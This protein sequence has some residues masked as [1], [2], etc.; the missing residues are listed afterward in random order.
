V[1]IAEL[2]PAVT[3][4]PLSADVEPGWHLCAVQIDFEAIATDR[5][6]LMERMRT[7]GIGT[8]VHYLPVNLHPFYRNRYGEIDLPGALSYYQRTL[9]L[10]LFPTMTSADVD[11]VVDELAAC[12]AR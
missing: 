9:S 3:L 8:Q 1:R 5:K 2:A 10:P 11:R 7:R 4:A 12:I 6:T